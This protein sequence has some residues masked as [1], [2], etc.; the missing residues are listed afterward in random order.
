VRTLDAMSLSAAK[1][2]VMQART[3]I[4]VNRIDE[5]ESTLAAAE[6]F[7]A[8]LPDEEKA[9]VLAEIAGIRTEL[10]SRMRPEDERSLR[11]AER[12]LKLAREQMAAGQD[13]MIETTLVRAARYLENVPDQHKAAI[14]A[15]LA[16]LRAPQAAPAPTPAPVAAAASDTPVERPRLAADDDKAAALVADAFVQEIEGWQRAAA[17]DLQSFED[18]RARYSPKDLDPSQAAAKQ[19][20]WAAKVRTAADAARAQLTGPRGAAALAEVGAWLA[21][22]DA[23]GAELRLLAEAFA[24]FNAE[25]EIA[26][27]GSMRLGAALDSVE[28]NFTRDVDRVVLAWDAVK[29]LIPALQAER[30]AAIREVQAVLARH[31]TLEQRVA[32][33]LRPLLAK[34]RVGPLVEKATHSLDLLRR[35]TDALDE[36]NVLRWRKALR[37]ALAPLERDWADDPDA[38]DFL[39]KCRRAFARS[40]DELGDRI[41]LREIQAAEVHVKPLVER[42]ERGLGCARRVACAITRRAC[43]RASTCSRRSSPTSARSSSTTAPRPRSAAS[44]RCSAPTSRARSA[45]PRRCR[46]SRSISPRTRACRRC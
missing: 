15:E 31:R 32:V 11:A 16:E 34:R 8:P 45:T 37:E 12:E 22:I 1:S 36:E 41:V 19:A 13:L 4:E 10:A 24:L 2:R 35:D 25:A 9:G 23:T 27:A 20:E 21:K 3:Q 28:W 43:S 18:A 7:L 17:R 5:A 39:A 14:L 6:R 44:R 42:V 30:F 40:E 33:E 46:A 29:K 26:D 38:Q